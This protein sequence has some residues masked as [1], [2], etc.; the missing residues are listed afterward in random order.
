M[1]V[2]VR[3]TLRSKPRSASNDWFKSET[4]EATRP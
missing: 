4:P 2:V 1:A 3:K